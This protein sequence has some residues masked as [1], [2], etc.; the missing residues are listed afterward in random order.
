MHAALS[1]VMFYSK[2][3]G[4]FLNSCFSHCQG[5]LTE[6]QEQLETLNRKLA[7]DNAY[8]KGLALAAAVDLKAL[9]EEVA[10]LMNHN[11]KLSTE[12]AAHRNS[13]VQRRPTG[14]TLISN[15]Y[16]FYIVR[17]GNLKLLGNLD[18][19]KWEVLGNLDIGY[20]SYLKSCFVQ[21][22]KLRLQH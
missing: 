17:F 1:S 6:S 12:L 5:E 7:E 3:G 14:S 22:K 11:E 10:K 19:C 13:P 18:M 20:F 8:A 4:T 16:D 9:L 2:R 15:F 21:K